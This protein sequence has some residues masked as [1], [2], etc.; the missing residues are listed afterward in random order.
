MRI[1]APDLFRPALVGTFA[2]EIAEM[3]D[4]SALVATSTTM[5]GLVGV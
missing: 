3:A 2:M 5:S 4:A 1:P